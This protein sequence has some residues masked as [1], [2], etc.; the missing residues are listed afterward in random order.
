[1]VATI[2]CFWCF[3]AGPWPSLGLLW[4]RICSWL[5]FF[6]PPSQRLSSDPIPRCRETCHHHAA[7]T[8]RLSYDAR[9]TSSSSAAAARAYILQ[10]RICLRHSNTPLV[11]PNIHDDR[12]SSAAPRAPHRALSERDLGIRR[13]KRAVGTERCPDA[14]RIGGP[15]DR[16]ETGHNIGAQ[17]RSSMSLLSLELAM[18]KCFQDHR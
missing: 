13:P 14:R 15:L 11:A 16:M 18:G 3:N 5:F 12:R 2:G 10:W 8:L 6:I 7:R 9:S 1:M 17:V 4:G